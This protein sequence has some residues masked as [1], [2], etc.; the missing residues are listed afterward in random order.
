MY[1]AVEIIIPL[2]AF[3]MIF[4]IVYVTVTAWHRQKMAMIESGMN[5]RE[6][7]H[8]KHSRLRTALLLLFVPVGLFVGNYLGRIMGHRLSDITG[9]V[10]AFFFGGLALLTSY[11]I[12]RKLENKNQID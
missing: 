3:A 1:Q 12:E 11:L 10:V 7:N 4:G 5:P 2:G 9:L 6:R 8:S